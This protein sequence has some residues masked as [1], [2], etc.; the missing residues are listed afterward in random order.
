MLLLALITSTLLGTISAFATSYIMFAI[1]R[2]LCG[3]AI[4]G[5]SIIGVV[6]GKNTQYYPFIIQFVSSVKSGLF[7]RTTKVQQE[8]VFGLILSRSG[9]KR[10]RER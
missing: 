8:L 10:E 1:S 5:L 9:D 2:A 4:S 6:L 3:V 7:F